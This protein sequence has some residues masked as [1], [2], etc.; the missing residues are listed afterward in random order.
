MNPSAC[1]AA[2]LPEADRIYLA[3]LALTGTATITD[4]AAGNG[5][6]RKFVYQPTRMGRPNRRKFREAKL[7][8]FR[9][10]AEPLSKRF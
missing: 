1:P 2:K 5:V 4:L 9:R 3:V 10:D 8:R 6:S 7:R